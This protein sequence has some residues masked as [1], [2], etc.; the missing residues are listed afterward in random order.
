MP[1]RLKP[2]LRDVLTEADRPLAGMWVSSGSAVVAEICAGSGLDWILIDMEHG[3]NGLESV[4]AQL[5]A[6]AAY[7]IIPAVRVPSADAT[8]LKQVLDIG[9]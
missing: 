7:D 9:A 1:I 6:V 3:P 2:T 8:V 4:L 5:H